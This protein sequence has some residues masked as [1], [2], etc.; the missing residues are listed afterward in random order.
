[1]ICAGRERKPGEAAS[2]GDAMDIS[3][4][5][6]EFVSL[7]RDLFHRL[8]SEEGQTLSDRG[9]ITNGDKLVTG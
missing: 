9:R 4:A 3:Q 1:M 2:V 6:S 7:R 8:R 5:V